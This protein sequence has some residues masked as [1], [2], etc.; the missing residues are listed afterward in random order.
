MR[1]NFDTPF[2]RWLQENGVRPLHLAQR[3]RLSRPTVLR[4]RKGSR[5]SDR[6]RAKLVAACCSLGQKRLT[7]A[8]LFGV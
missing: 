7:E 1:A 3:A 8:E 2:D 5:G 6:T 4:I